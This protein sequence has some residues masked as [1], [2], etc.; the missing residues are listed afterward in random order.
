VRIRHGR[1]R[2]AAIIAATI[3]FAGGAPA[4]VATDVS[5]DFACPS[6][7]ANLSVPTK[8][9]TV[10]QGESA[11]FTI[12]IHRTDCPEA[13]SFEP[14]EVPPPGTTATF[15]PTST[16]GDSVTLT[17]TTSPTTPLPGYAFGVRPQAEGVGPG[18]YW[19]LD[20][21]ILPSITPVTST[22]ASKLTKGAIGASSTPVRTSWTASDPDGIRRYE[23]QRRVNG[24]SWKPVD[25]ASRTST[26]VRQALA[27]DKAYRYRVRATDTMGN[28][29]AW[30]YGPTFRPRLIQQGSDR[31]TSPF[32][33]TNQRVVAASG[34]SLKYNPYSGSEFRFRFRAQSVGFVSVKGPTRTNRLEVS[35]DDQVLMTNGSLRTKTVKYRQ[36]VAVGN[37]PTEELRELWVFNQGIQGSERLDIDAIV[38]LDRS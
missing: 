31:I 20:V 10:H 16:T 38:L 19:L 4:A 25:L 8:E 29:G 34:G 13:V 18:G 21:V 33:W 6:G 36:L 28:L 7:S 1:V 24:G 3:L 9:Q 15:S 35:V 12:T 26:S 37:W 32:N 27:F 22:P 14:I 2:L 30:S 11:V 17:I 23:V 5:P